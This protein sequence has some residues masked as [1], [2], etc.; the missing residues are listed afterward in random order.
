MSSKLLRTQR[1][2]Q[3]HHQTQT[4][5]LT[6]TQIQPQSLMLHLL[7]SSLFPGKLLLGENSFDEM[8]V[9]SRKN[10]HASCGTSFSCRHQS[11]TSFPFEIFT[12]ASCAHDFCS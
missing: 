8:N 2:D 9:S 3:Q 1:Q 7:S 4:Q 6:L 12:H 11:L 10:S 5:I